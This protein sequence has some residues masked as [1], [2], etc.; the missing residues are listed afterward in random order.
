MLLRGARLHPAH[1][2]GGKGARVGSKLMAAA[3]R[4]NMTIKE[5]NAIRSGRRGM[6]GRGGRRKEEEGRLKQAEG[7]RRA[8][9]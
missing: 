4:A 2:A 8:S 7:T 5:A 3:V 1:L 9:L 6:V